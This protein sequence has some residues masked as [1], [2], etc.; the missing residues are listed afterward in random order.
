MPQFCW[1]RI[2]LLVFLIVVTAWRT[3]DCFLRI[4]TELRY[5]VRSEKVPALLHIVA[6]TCIVAAIVFLGQ[7]S[8]QSVRGKQVTERFL[9]LCQR[10]RFSAKAVRLMFLLLFYLPSA[11]FTV[12]VFPLFLVSSLLSLDGTWWMGSNY[13]LVVC[14]SDA[15]RGA[16]YYIIH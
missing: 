5:Q 8:P 3:F 9:A 2:N 12:V 7:P 6:P 13:W 11:L 1:V 10:L 15:E 4:V 14:V 16:F